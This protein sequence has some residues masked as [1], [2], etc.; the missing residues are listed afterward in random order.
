LSVK[1]HEEPSRGGGAVKLEAADLHRR[2]LKGE[3]QAWRALYGWCLSKAAK[4]LPQ[5]AEAVAQQVCLKL[6]EGGLE[7]VQN[8]KAF[9]GYVSRATTNE[10]IN[11][12]RARKGN[13]SLDQPLSGNDDETLLLGHTVADESDP[14]EE[15]AAARLMLSR[16]SAALSELP[17]YCRGVMKEYVRYRMGLVESYKEMAGILG[18]SVNTLGV[19]IKRCLD[20]LRTLPAFMELQA[21]WNG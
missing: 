6:L 18:V 4:T 11:R 5:E 13:L 2:C 17:A 19:Q 15:Q 3:E 14:P 8:P 7:R 10:I 21:G 12:L 20:Q 9:L 16:M 1:K